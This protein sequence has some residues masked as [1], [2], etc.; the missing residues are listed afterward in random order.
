MDI[1]ECLYLINAILAC[2]NNIYIPIDEK[3]YAKGVKE[4]SSHCN[5]LLCVRI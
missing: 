2:E 3:V 5:I 4:R 1:T